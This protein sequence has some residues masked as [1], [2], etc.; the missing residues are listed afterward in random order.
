MAEFKAALPSVIKWSV[1]DNQ[2]DE[3]GSNPKSLS[4]FIPN[5][6]ISALAA[7]LQ[8]MAADPGKLKRGKIWDYNR[9]EEVE[10]E[11]V[12]LNAKGKSGDYGDFGNINPKAIGS[13]PTQAL[14][15]DLP[16]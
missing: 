8:L 12:Y 1:G 5:A 9:N 4:L 13:A 2:Y 15:A 6:S 3:D 11:G 14:P 10:V 7:H 16:F